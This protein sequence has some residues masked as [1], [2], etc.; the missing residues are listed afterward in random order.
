LKTT[1]RLELPALTALNAGSRVAFALLDRDRNILRSG[2]LPLSDIASSV[3]GSR[4]EGIL[5]PGDSIVTTVT[6]PPL[7]THRM[8][9]AVAGAVEPLLLGDIDTLAIAYSPRAA[10][11][12]V[13]VAWSQRADLADAL[14]L[15]SACGLTA[16]A[17][18]PAPLALPLADT[19]WTAL[20][21]DGFVVVRCAAQA[22]YCWAIDPLAPDD[23]SEPAKAALLLALEQ[24]NPPSIAWIEPRP[25]NWVSPPGIDTHTLPA[26]DRWRGAVPAWSLALPD[27]R[28]R[29]S[30][31]S[32]WR[33]PLM[34]TAGAAAVWLLG[35]NVH[36]W[37]LQREE[38]TLRERM[39][40]QVK[41]A[42][43]DLPVIVDPLRQAEQRRDA[44]RTAGGTFGESD[45]L[46]LALAV[47][48]LLPQAASNITTLTFADA[49][50]RMRLVDE[51]IGMTSPTAPPAGSASALRRFGFPRPPSSTTSPPVQAGA[52]PKAEID[53]AIVQRAQTLNLKVSRVDGEWRI[54]PASLDGTD[55]Q[56]SPNG[57]TIQN[58]GNSR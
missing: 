7:P 48:Q 52:A 27:L 22:G 47:A 24:D 16:D 39:I 3:P 44:L 8:A 18:I 54:R 2:E 13:T 9:A 57:V 17:L 33:R 19:G 50:L 36:A 38:R 32:R 25:A 20:V 45:F 28:P 29:R 35:L 11:G 56:Q 51:N 26:D 30:A 43:P 1:L 21:R 37:Q 31:A 55:S 10:D 12:T 41:T 58:S 49:E 40:N 46:P 23:G 34:W 5:H 14:Q 6:V 4:V 42:F 53:P 15:L